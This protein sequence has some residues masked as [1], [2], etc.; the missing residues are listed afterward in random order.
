ML[1]FKDYSFYCLKVGGF[2]LHFSKVRVFIVPS[3]NWGVTSSNIC[4]FSTGA[5]ANNCIASKNERFILSA[6][7][8]TMVGYN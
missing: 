7:V 6:G 3:V 8:D 4:T 2:F 5:S 1:L